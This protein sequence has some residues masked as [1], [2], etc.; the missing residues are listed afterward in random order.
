MTINLIPPKLK[1]ERQLETYVKA[2]TSY[3]GL[4]LFILLL[5]SATIFISNQLTEYDI[6]ST[7]TKIEATNEQIA[8]YKEV[9]T[10]LN[11]INSK[12]EKISSQEENNVIWSKVAQELGNSTPIE[13]QVLSLTLKSD[14]R[15]IN[16]SGMAKT[17]R[18][19]AKM[20]E[21]MEDSGFFKNITFSSNSVYNSTQDLFSFT[22]NG[23]LETIK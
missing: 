17:R 19:I 10:S 23:E 22:L 12:M 8:K 1:K 15:S 2:G 4:V 21:K 5:V 16:V 20:K 13:V 11:K 6:A 14:N 3:L 9:E 18:D 7:K